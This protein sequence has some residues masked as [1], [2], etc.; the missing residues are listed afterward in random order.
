VDKIFTEIGNFA[1]ITFT[2]VK[3]QIAGFEI[4]HHDEGLRETA[5]KYGLARGEFRISQMSGTAATLSFADFFFKAIMNSASQE[6]LLLLWNSEV[7]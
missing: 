5:N 2:Q 3:T 7:H 4:R 6:N 1:E